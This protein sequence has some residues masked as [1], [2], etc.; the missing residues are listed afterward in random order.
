LRETSKNTYVFEGFE[1]FWD[2]QKA[3]AS[4]NPFGPPTADLIRSIRI[5]PINSDPTMEDGDEDG[6]LDIDEFEWNKIDE[7]YKGVSPLKADTVES[8]YPELLAKGSSN[9][10]SNPIYLEI[11]GNHIK[12]NIRYSFSNNDSN[13]TKEEL[14]NGAK[15]VW[16]HSYDVPNNESDIKDQLSYFR[17]KLYDFYPGMKITVELNFIEIDNNS[18]E[19]NYFNEN[20]AGRSQIF[21]TYHK[22]WFNSNN[23]IIEVYKKQASN[24]FILEDNLIPYVFS[25]ELGHAMGLADAYGELKMGDDLND[26]FSICT[27]IEDPNS[28]FPKINGYAEFNAGEI[29][30]T[31]GLPCSNDIEMILQAFCENRV[32]WFYAN[33]TDI[34]NQEKFIS[35]AIKNPIII[36]QRK[37]RVITTDKETG[38]R[39]DTEET[40]YRAYKQYEEISDTNP[41]T[42]TNKTEIEGYL[43]NTN[44]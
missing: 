25:H 23:S 40:L 3:I 36:Y 18:I 17:G 2:E 16:S 38:E 42:T 41:V 43:N 5:L 9:S 15:Y 11:K 7:R 19:I 13:I 27:E 39:K 26:G 22:S 34:K 8:L 30:V 6:I 28:E 4:Q 14:L 33:P 31:N 1:Y 35:K 24:G 32:Q 12:I 37:Y 10:D 44:N 29:M 20:T 21:D